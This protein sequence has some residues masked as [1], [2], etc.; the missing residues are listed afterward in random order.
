M[1]IVA[2]AMARTKPEPKPEPERDRR[3]LILVH[4]RHSA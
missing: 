3:G 1:D 2:P 4:T